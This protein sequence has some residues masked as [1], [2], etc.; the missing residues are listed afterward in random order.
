[1]SHLEQRIS[2]ACPLGQAASRLTQFFTEHGNASA[3][4]A[5]LSLKLDL[6][7]PGVPIPISL[8]RSVIATIQ[9]HRRPSDMT[10]RFDVQWAPEKAG[11]LPLFSGELVVMA[12]E[13]YR[14]FDLCLRGDYEPPMGIVGAGF[15][16]AIGNRVAHATADQLLHS[17]RDLIEREFQSDEARKPHQNGR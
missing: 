8:A 13:D 3:D 12:H 1:M 14:S 7:V 6:S 15:D 11:P 5:K 17:V 2:V 16:A 10:P 4:T 9:P